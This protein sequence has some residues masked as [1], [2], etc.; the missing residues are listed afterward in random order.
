MSESL[1][2]ESI[3]SHGRFMRS[4]AFHLVRD[5]S[6][7]DDLVQQTWLTA[8]KHS[9][10]TKSN[11]RAWLAHVMRNLARNEW[12][13]LEREGKK[14]RSYSAQAT[15]TARSTD[16]I[17]E[18]EE[19]Q[20]DLLQAVL[21]LEE[22]YRTAVLHRFYDGMKPQKIAATLDVPKATVKKR[23]ERGLEKL[24]D[25]LD[26]KHG[27]KRLSWLLPLIPVAGLTPTAKAVALAGPTLVLA[28]PA[29]LSVVQKSLLATA[30]IL[31]SIAGIWYFG[32]SAENDSFKRAP[33][34]P[35][36]SEEDRIAMGRRGDLRVPGQEEFN[37]KDKNGEPS[38][39]STITFSGMVKGR[40][41]GDPIP[42]FDFLLSRESTMDWDPISLFN[43]RIESKDGTFS[44]DLEQAGI[45]RLF[46]YAPGFLP[47]WEQVEI[48]A[49]SG[50]ENYS[51]MIEPGLS[52]S[53]EVLDDLTGLPLSGA[54][55]RGR[56]AGF[57]AP[58]AQI[59]TCTSMHPAPQIIVSL[60]GREGS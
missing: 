56:D 53:G 36:K 19:T 31:M 49:D 29:A 18:A 44:F 13:D 58:P 59:R 10:W 60:H 27:G 17:V 39:L 40:V 35:R 3:L 42:S 9:I 57:P 6:L 32:S 52:I 55:G 38:T 4:L 7:A 43:T 28:K 12:R 45:H 54:I 26:K 48:P 16:D 23:L 8:F 21:G 37:S 1:N 51:V 11:P 25:S 22:P 2:Q 50:L 24:R 47:Y 41:T 34:Q 20:K 30:A 14:E 33:L 5:D 15:E 46:I